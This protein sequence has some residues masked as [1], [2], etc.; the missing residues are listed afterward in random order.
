MLGSLHPQTLDLKNF[1]KI[2]ISRDPGM[3]PLVK[4][5][6][7]QPKVICAHKQSQTTWPG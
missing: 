1:K 7:N 2:S 3:E 6:D 5:T 4:A